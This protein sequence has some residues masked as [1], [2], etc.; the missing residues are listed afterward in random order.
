MNKP[1][2]T[3]HEKYTEVRLDGEHSPWDMLKVTHALSKN[4]P[5]KKTPS[6]WILGPDF[7]FSIHGYQIFIQG[8]VNFLARNIKKGARTAIVAVDEFQKSKTKFFCMEAKSFPY[9]LK[10]F[11]SRDKALEWALE[12]V[13]K[14]PK[15]EIPE[16]AFS[17]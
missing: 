13:T 6:L 2:I 14:V 5:M 8:I 9:E 7:N 3:Q 4:D 15:Q 16:N 11:T 10:A 12:N 1:V 17:R